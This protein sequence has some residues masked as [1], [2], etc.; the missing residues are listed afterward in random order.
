MKMRVNVGNLHV[1][2][3]LGGEKKVVRLVGSRFRIRKPLGTG[4]VGIM[5]WA[6]VFYIRR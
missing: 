5:G 3:R 2:F 4:G 6:S 1:G